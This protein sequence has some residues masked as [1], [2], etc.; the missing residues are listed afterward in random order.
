MRQEETINQ[1][2]VLD[3]IEID[4]LLLSNFTRMIATAHLLSLKDHPLSNILK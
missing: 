2:K 4:A 3:Q 1:L